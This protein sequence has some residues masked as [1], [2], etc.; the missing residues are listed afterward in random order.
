M[1]I[2]F[3]NI[4]KKDI[5]NKRL[6]IFFW[7]SWSGKSTYLEFFMKTLDTKDFV[8]LFHKEKKIIFNKYKQKYIF[9]DEIVNVYWLYVVLRYL[10]DWKIIVVASHIEP[11]IYKILFGIFIKWN[12]FFTD[13]NNKKI[14]YHLE[15][16]WYIYNAE[17]IEKFISNFWWN[18][19]E[20]DIILN[21]D[22]E[23]KNFSEVLTS[24]LDDCVITYKENK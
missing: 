12:Y 23:N 13:T 11:F 19:I 1:F 22:K 15:N 21:H 20:L 10:L 5:L 18:F 24:F 9:I 3:L 14:E 7:K 4:T 16:L 6:S 8:F 2:D 17:S